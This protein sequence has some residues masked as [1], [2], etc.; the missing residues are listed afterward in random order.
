MT[1]YEEK[2]IDE[3]QWRPCETSININ[4]APIMDSKITNEESFNNIDEYN[5]ITDKKY[6]KVGATMKDER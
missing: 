2:M 5:M 1:K 3:I 4:D 6:L